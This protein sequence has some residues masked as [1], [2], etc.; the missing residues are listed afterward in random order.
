M[1]Q[2]RRSLL[3]DDENGD[4][5]MTKAEYESKRRQLEERST[6]AMTTEEYLIDMIALEKLDT[7]AKEAGLID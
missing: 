4:C 6:R 5:S 3:Y 7:K 1:K 2:D